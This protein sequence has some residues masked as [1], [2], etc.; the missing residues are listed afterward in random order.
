MDVVIRAREAGDLPQLA[1]VL[2]LCARTRRLSGRRR[3]NPTAW[4]TPPRELAAWTALYDGQ[5][6]GHI[7]LTQASETDDAARLWQSATGGDLAQ[8]AV[9]VRL[10]VDPPHRQRGA[11]TLL[12][13]AAQKYATTRNLAIAFDVMLKD[14]DAI[15]LYEAAGC[16]RLERSS[17][18]GVRAKPSRLR[19]TPR[20]GLN[21]RND[22]CRRTK[23]GQRLVRVASGKQRPSLSAQPHSF[24]TTRDLIPHRHRRRRVPQPATEFL[25]RGAGPRG[26]VGAVVA[27]VV[28]P[29]VRF[30]DLEHAAPNCLVN[31]V[32]ER[33]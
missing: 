18:G 5:P 33:R 29:Q 3:A 17:T 1:E 23:G 19:C 27:K 24:T 6:I 31:A 21:A 22:E 2:A 14:K 13:Q 25:C 20:R 9:P 15:R 16:V 32:V 30:P 8:L 12:M 28:Y 7:S 10:F 26:Q 4:L 11:G